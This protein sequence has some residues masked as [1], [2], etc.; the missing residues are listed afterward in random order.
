MAAVPTP[1]AEDVVTDAVPLPAIVLNVH[2]EPLR[3]NLEIRCSGVAAIYI[4]FPAELTVMP[5]ALTFVLMLLTTP[6]FVII[7]IPFC[8]D[9]AMK[10]LLFI[11]TAIPY[12]PLNLASVSLPFAV[13]VVPAAPA[14]V[15]TVVGIY[16]GVVTSIS[17]DATPAGNIPFIAVT[18][19]LY[20][21]GA[22]R[23]DK[24]NV[25]GF[26]CPVGLVPTEDPVLLTHRYVYLIPSLTR[27]PPVQS[28]VMAFPSF[29]T[30]LSTGAVGRGTGTIR[31]I[32]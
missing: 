32:R 5:K 15:P 12:G 1:S 7:R 2:V 30:T 9:S 14:Y 18:L 3:I 17:A 27:P 8:S 6:V 24:R 19:I 11:S 29:L 16:A 23:S 21:A 25:T 28:T 26:I 4:I 10:T 13:P 20:A 31:R 22:V